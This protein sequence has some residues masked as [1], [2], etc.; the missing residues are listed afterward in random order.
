MTSRRPYRDREL[1][2]GEALAELKRCAGKQFDPVIVDAFAK[3]NEK[4]AQRALPS[5]Q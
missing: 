3:L 2:A 5:L 4:A 1:T